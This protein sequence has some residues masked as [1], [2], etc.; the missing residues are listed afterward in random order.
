MKI[1]PLFSP[2]LGCQA[3]AAMWLLSS[4]SLFGAVPGDEH[5]DNQFGP[6][7]LNGNAYGVA[8]IG[9]KVYA[10]G[11]FTA[12]GGT[13][14]PGV[15]GF[16]GTNWFPLNG[17]LPYPGGGSPTVIS[18]AVDN[19][20]LYA[21]GLFSSGDD[22]TAID[23]ARWDGTN[24]AGIGIQGITY[25][26]KRNGV[27]LY[28]CG[29]FS[30]AGGVAA[31]NIA[32]WDG[33]NWF[34]LGP[35]VS[36]PNVFPNTP[37]LDC[38]AVQGNNVYVGGI[39]SYA[40]AS[41][42]TNIAY[43]DGSTWHAMGN[44]FNGLVD[45]L[46]FYGGYLYAGG[47]FTNTS[48]H[49]TN[50]ARWDGSAWSALPGGGANRTVSDF[51]T[52]GTNL[53]MCGTFTA[54]GGIAA[55][56]VVSFDGNNW[57][58]LNSGL[59]YFQAQ[60]GLPQ[61]F[62]LCWASNQLYVVGG[63]DRA[64]NSGAINIARWDGTNWWSVG[65]DTSKGMGIGIDFEQSLFLLTNAV[66]S[67]A[68]PAGLYAGGLFPV[69][70]RTNANLIA[71]F[72]GTNWNPLGSGMSGAFGG[73]AN[74]LTITTDGTYL[75]A[76]GNFT[77]AG[78]YTGIGGIAEWD[79]NNWYPLGYG[80]DYIV[81]ALVVDGYGYLWVGGS[82][83]NAVNA[84]AAKGLVVWA[85]GNWYDFGSVAGTNAIVS[86]LA[87]DGGTRIYVGG[88]FYSVGGVSATNIAY[89][90][91]SDSSWHPLVLGVN[92][93]VNALACG[94]GLLYA[95]GTFTQAGSVA[96][97]HVAQWNGT[98]WS[99]LGSGI[100]GANSPSVVTAIAPSGNN[101]Y[102]A[103]NFTNAGGILASNVAVWNG[104]SWLAL[105]SGTTSSTSP[106][107]TGIAAAGN[108][109]YIGG[110]FN[111]AGDKPAQFIAH[112]NSQSNY[113]PVANLK[114][115]RSAWQTN[116]LFRFRVTGTSGQSYVIQGTT[117]LN[118]WTPLQTNSAMF[119]DFVDAAS[120]NYRSRYYRALLGP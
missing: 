30:S 56:N 5:W 6:P 59:H 23:T 105:G 50:V 81:D 46:Q 54:I 25:A 89:Y 108:D 110:R 37:G 94:N 4:I 119:Y 34:A 12:A 21:G 82:F 48:L 60:I 75:Y 98:S 15:A 35:G 113:Y 43:W 91:Y 13:K 102:F 19:I 10:A 120:T 18:L 79:G 29:T 27:N 101:V 14:T 78:A 41:S 114:L 118:A 68:I 96:V 77:N 100:S 40:G 99:A 107:T 33:T 86:A 9:N 73:S 88:Q 1:R 97:N 22:P 116:R 39:F 47:T 65:G 115:T 80:L 84:G 8:V 16:D 104:T 45:A 76:G 52:D 49:L 7:G 31:T 85:G 58:P 67:G 64:D 53:F 66:N 24:W 71:R 74:V 32:R 90:D 92:T 95:G 70:G 26:V 109:V 61:A 63:F 87:Y 17:G 106:L 44:P 57:K 11:L 55:T 112:W 36:G 62:K 83:T 103:G 38:M 93:K 117:N 2:V 51:A 3:F 28:F 111:F 42:M 69:A 20:Y 72:D